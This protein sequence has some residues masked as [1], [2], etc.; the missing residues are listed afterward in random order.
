MNPIAEVTHRAETEMKNRCR[1]KDMSQ[2]ISFF[3][4]EDYESKKKTE[5]QATSKGCGYP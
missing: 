5:N 4:E 2:G 1:E 3:S